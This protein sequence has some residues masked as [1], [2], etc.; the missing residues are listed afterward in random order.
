M[1][2][3]VK[4]FLALIVIALL[5][6]TSIATAQNMSRWI[7][8]TVEPDN[9]MR[10]DFIAGEAN[11]PIRI[12]S[13]STDTTI[14]AN[15][16]WPYYPNLEFNYYADSTTMIIYGNI[17]GFDCRF[18]YENL[19]GLDILNNTLLTELLCLGNNLTSLDLSNATALKDLICGNN[20]LTTLDVSGATALES[21]SCPDNVI[22][23]LNVSGATNLKFIDCKNNN[24]SSLN[25]AGPVA[26]EEVDLSGND[27]TSFDFSGLTTLKVLICR[28]NNFTSLDVSKLVALKY[29]DCSYNNIA[30]LDVSGLTALEQLDCSYNSLTSLD[31]NG[32]SFLKNIKCNNNDLTSL[33]ISYLTGLESLLCNDNSL[34]TLDLSGLSSI[35]LLDCQKNNL[36]SLDV[37]GL[38]ELTNLACNDNSLTS[39]DISDL[40]SLYNLK[41]QKN[42]LTSLDVSKLTKLRSLTCYD[43]S[44][45][46]QALDQ[47]Y[48]DLPIIL[49]GVGGWIFPIYDA[50]SSNYA[51]VMA[52]NSQNAIDR[53]W[54]VRYG[55]NSANI[56][57][58]TGTYECETSISINDITETNIYPN[59]VSDILYINTDSQIKS[60]ELYDV[61][62]RM[63][64]NKTNLTTTD[65]TVDVSH[66]NSGIY[67]L[68]LNTT[69]GTGDFK[70]V[71]R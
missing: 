68:R 69:K 18:N 57:A 58:T 33:N 52:T 34:T 9:F 37:S 45:S 8:L 14:M 61:Y 13:G 28:Y 5:A 12:I 55:S 23:S 32:L 35:K 15:T 62:G 42:S 29:L 64:L 25:L 56:P 11:T 21:L 20:S 71:K 16:Q 67:V 3:I 39:I 1:K 40:T 50:S 48:C 54:S 6:N 17:V 66:L 7:E 65:I 38:S 41:C 10:I 36:T 63:V 49:A 59:P 2:T 43:N 51:T 30:S 31:I 27:F 46:T 44:F 24:L 22:T 19:T 53:S 60:I 26:L 47:I 4:K 70:V